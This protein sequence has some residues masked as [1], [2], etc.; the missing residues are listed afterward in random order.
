M[1]VYLDDILVTW[2]SETDHLCNLAEVLRRLQAVSMQLKQRVPVS[3]SRSGVIGSPNLKRWAAPYRRED[4]GYQE[5]SAIPK[6]H[7]TKVLPWAVEL[8]RKVFAQIVY[9]IC[10]LV[11]YFAETNCLDLGLESGQ[12]IHCSQ[13]N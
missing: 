4:P 10:P 1:T 9:H 8:L 12:G 5:C 11:Q 13:V 6:H 3:P 2:K 7:S